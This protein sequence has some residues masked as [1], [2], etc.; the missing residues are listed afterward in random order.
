MPQ[1]AAWQL[2]VAHFEY[3][4]AEPNINEINNYTRSY[5]HG[6]LI[7]A[8]I[9]LIVEQ[10]QRLIHRRTGFVSKVCTSLK[11]PKLMPVN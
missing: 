8:I 7:P 3:G 10:N 6:E 1:V 11:Y 2:A 4:S 5:Y 9:E